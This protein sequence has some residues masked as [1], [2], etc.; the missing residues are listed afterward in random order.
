[1]AKKPHQSKSIYNRRVQHDYTLEQSLVV[2]IQLT[3]SETRALRLGL[4]QLRGAYITVKDNELWLI[5]TT[6]SG[7]G[8]NQ[9]SEPDQ[10]RARKLLAKRKEISQ[11]LEAK[12]QGRTIL[13]LEILTH[14]RYIKVRIVVGK[15]KKQYDK[16]QTLKKRDDLRRSQLA[17]KNL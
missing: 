12:Q 7:S 5:N 1:M 9:I 6:I 14:G 3:G 16:R 8:G 17:I 10:T 4:G 2:G 11:L 13:P 15:G